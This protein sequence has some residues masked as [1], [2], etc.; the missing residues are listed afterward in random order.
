MPP[1][2][3]NAQISFQSLASRCGA[4]ARLKL[5][6]IYAAYA[7]KRRAEHRDRIIAGLV[8][9]DFDRSALREQLARAVYA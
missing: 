2:R 9:G 4:A 3:F 6:G 8:G 1:G 5:A 7:L